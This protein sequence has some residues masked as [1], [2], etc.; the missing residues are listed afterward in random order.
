MLPLTEEVA[1]DIWLELGG[2]RC[3]AGRLVRVLLKRGYEDATLDMVRDWYVRGWQKRMAQRETMFLNRL[4]QIKRTLAKGVDEARA[5][6]GSDTAIA[7]LTHLVTVLSI[8]AIG[9]LDEFRPRSLQD[10]MTMATVASKIMHTI[11]MV[12]IRLMEI[13]PEM[14]KEI[15]SPAQE[16]MAPLAG[17]ALDL[18]P[19]LQGAIEAYSK[20]R[21]S[22]TT[23][24]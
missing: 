24:N 17:R 14:A 15:K 21:K 3:H 13:A 9:E 1:F 16:A 23:V 5:V 4:N 19:Q 7:A 2:N 10:V 11:S 8:K 6:G 20:A 22:A 12:R 18:V